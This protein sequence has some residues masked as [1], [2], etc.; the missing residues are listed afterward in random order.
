MRAM[1]NFTLLEKAELAGMGAATL[2]SSLAPSFEFRLGGIITCASLL[3]LL[4]GFCRDL[5]LWRAARRNPTPDAPRYAACMCV[6]STLG[7]TGILAAAGLTAF[8]F[9]PVYAITQPWLT[10]GVTAVLVTGFLLKDFVFQWSPW[11]IYR[12][13]HH[14]T[15]HF[16]WRR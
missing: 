16:K 2:L 8:R 15:L 4:Q 13:K 11:R 14:A 6:E 5:W 12:E 9:G 3:L 7:L 10:L 1:R